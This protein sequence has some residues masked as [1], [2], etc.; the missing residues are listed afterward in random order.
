MDWINCNTLLP[1]PTLGSVHLNPCLPPLFTWTLCL[2]SHLQLTPVLGWRPQFLAPFFLVFLSWSHGLFWVLFWVLTL[3]CRSTPLSPAWHWINKQIS[4]NRNICLQAHFTREKGIF[5]YQKYIYFK[6]AYHSLKFTGKRESQENQG[7]LH[8]NP[9][10]C[11]KISRW[12]CRI[13]RKRVCFAYLRERMFKERRGL[14]FK[15]SDMLKIAF[16]Q[17]WPKN[18][19]CSYKSWSGPW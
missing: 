4:P 3:S 8:Y 19:L 18:H 17:L 11:P 16:G 14:R 12:T 7:H 6:G 10:Q 2:F 15:I 13:L 5:I 1:V 9:P